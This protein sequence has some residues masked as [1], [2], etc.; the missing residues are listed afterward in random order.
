MLT[1]NPLLIQATNL[2]K[3]FADNHVLKGVNIDILKG[4]STTLIG[5]SGSGK[6]LLFK[7]LLG[8][9]K[10]DIGEILVN[11]QNLNLSLIHI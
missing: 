10:P 5:P 4:K 9:V 2:H 8:L 3:N 11:G 7:C 6:T 1:D